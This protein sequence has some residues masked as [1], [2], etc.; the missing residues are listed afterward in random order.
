MTNNIKY[1]IGNLKMYGNTNYLKSMQK[2]INFSY[3]KKHKKFKIV[4]CPPY[5]ILSDF[6]K[7][8]KNTQI[9]VGAQ[10]CHH[11]EYTGS[12]TGSISPNMIKSIGAK[13]IIIGHSENRVT[14]ETN[15]IINKKIISTLSQKL[16]VIFCIGETS[17]EKKLNK[18]NSV[19]K[20][21]I[22]NGLKNIKKIDKI[23]FAYEPVWCIGKGKIPK[24]NDI[25]NQFKYI[26][27]I[28]FKNFKTLNPT[29]VYGGSVD[30]NNVESLCQI[31]EIKGFLIGGASRKPNKFID[32]V[33]KSIN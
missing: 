29:I 26:K 19:L 23:I 11:N 32:I 2:V 13:Y 25:K 1:F 10:N 20:K 21:Q 18:T 27:K 16:N 14:G 17:K 15:S 33:K 24:T 30:Q 5:T 6:V 31:N 4:F 3:K 12:F 7:L 8:T 9:E 22:I 28:L